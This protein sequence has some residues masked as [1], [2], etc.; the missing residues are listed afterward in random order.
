L[1]A[2]LFFVAAELENRKRL[3]TRAV[4]FDLW[5]TLILDPPDVSR[6]RQEWRAA[7]VCEVLRQSGQDV[8][9]KPVDQALIG[10]M[11]RLGE[12]Q[13]QGLD[14]GHGGRARLFA[15]VLHQ[16]A[17]FALH[18]DCLEDVEAAVT[19][20]P[21]EL[22]PRVE[23]FALTALAEVKSLGFATALVSNAGFTTAP[24]LRSL[25]EAHGLLPYL[26]RLVFSDEIEL[27]KPDPRV[28][29]TA[30][31]A[32]G[33]TREECVFVGDSPHND[34]YGA[35]RAGLLAVQIGARSREGIV[36]SATIQNLGEL[37]PLLRSLDL[38]PEG[39]GAP[40]RK[41]AQT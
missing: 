20:M 15:D 29:L 24:H 8:P 5:G 35:Q 3:A 40:D 26:D 18:D 28:F 31:E 21:I 37:V 22:A 32:L 23:P 34:I 33:V 10:A 2:P 11:R 1:R 13:D 41:G 7:R 12:M 4:L 36:A 6:P 9:F 27:A 14:L 19:C 39:S 17:G 25:I 38:L 30:V 16:T